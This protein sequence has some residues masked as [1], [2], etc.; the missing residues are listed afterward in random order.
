M[1]L[2]CRRCESHTPASMLTTHLL[3]CLLASRSLGLTLSLKILR[4]REAQ[5]TENNQHYL[6]SLAGQE[7]TQQP[8]TVG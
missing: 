3:Y 6:A 2:F 4:E 5:R 7:E 8:K 1:Y